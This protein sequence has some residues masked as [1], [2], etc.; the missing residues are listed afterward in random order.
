[1]NN[2]GQAL[3]LF[4]II[5]PVLMFLFICFYQIG[6]NKI[7]DK[8]LKESIKEAIE[9]GLDN[10]EREDVD[11]VIKEMIISTNKDIKEEDIEISISDNKI[12]VKVLRKYSVMFISDDTIT[13]DYVGKIND[14]KIEIMENRGW[15]NENG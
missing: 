11:I 9:F 3:A 15:Y 14:D 13:F 2:R 6:T 10:L 12:N 1:M 5:L 4:I 7:E 8:R